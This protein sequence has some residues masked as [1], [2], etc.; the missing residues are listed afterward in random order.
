VTFAFQSY[1]HS[2]NGKDI[3]SGVDGDENMRDSGYG[4]DKE[5]GE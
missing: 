2:Q 4:Y 5:D 3:T 1:G